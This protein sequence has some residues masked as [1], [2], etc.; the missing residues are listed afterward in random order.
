MLGARSGCWEVPASDSSGCWDLRDRTGWAERAGGAVGAEREHKVSERCV[1]QQTSAR[2][3]L[4][5]LGQ[6]PHLRDD[7]AR[8]LRPHLRDLRAS[9]VAAQQQTDGEERVV[10][11]RPVHI[12]LK[13]LKRAVINIIGFTNIMIG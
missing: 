7:L 10:R 5:L 1:V 12:V 3:I 6:V 4:D 2:A 11:K 9:V 8:L 13:L